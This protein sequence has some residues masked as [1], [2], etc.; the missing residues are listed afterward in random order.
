M[1]DVARISV[2]NHHELAF[3]K[4]QTIP[5]T[6]NKKASTN[7]Y[8][9]NF[10]TTLFKT[11]LTPSIIIDQP[12]LYNSLAT[13]QLF[14]SV[15]IADS[16]NTPT[17]PSGDL[18]FS[19][20][21]K[22]EM[23][24]NWEVTG[25]CNFSETCAFAHGGSELRPKLHVSTKY[26]TKKC[27]QYFTT[28]LCA[29]GRRCQF[30]HDEDAQTSPTS[31]AVCTPKSV[32]NQMK[33]ESI[34]TSSINYTKALNSVETHWDLASEL[35]TPLFAKKRLVAFENITK[36]NGCISDSAGESDEFDDVEDFGAR[37]ESYRRKLNV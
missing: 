4:M 21:Y 32:F 1:H 13:Q 37:I 23:C 35:P 29:Y 36:Q 27:R 33:E 28:G 9:F 7:T 16:L 26:K 5:H 3:A 10:P 15:G 25:M 31:T 17:R 30:L 11:P 24:K 2:N 20:K 12:T 8:Q 14:L 22:T 6:I 19:S 18:N 34:Q